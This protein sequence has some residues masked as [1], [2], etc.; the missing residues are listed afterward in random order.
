MKERGTGDEQPEIDHD[1]GGV[2]Q[3]HDGSLLQVY[4]ARVSR[5][6]TANL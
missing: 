3:I 1:S 6:G 2:L 5:S 4:G